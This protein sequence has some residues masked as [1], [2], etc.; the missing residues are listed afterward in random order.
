MAGPAWCDIVSAVKLLYL[1][2][3]SR[4]IELLQMACVQDE[5]DCEITG[6]MDRA[7]FIAALQSGRY[8]GILSDS[9]IHDLPAPEALKL[10][11]SLAPNLPYVFLCGMMSDAKKAELLAAGPDGIFSKDRPEDLGL[12]IGLLRKLAGERPKRPGDL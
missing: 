10:A 12:A 8:A 3:D 7:S 4:D 6:A 9:G 11:R 2:D 1:E 5:P